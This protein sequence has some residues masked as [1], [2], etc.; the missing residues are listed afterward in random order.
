MYFS[1]G[2]SDHSNILGVLGGGPDIKTVVGV[3]LYMYFNHFKDC[4]NS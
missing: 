4:I 1:K 2:L 3:V